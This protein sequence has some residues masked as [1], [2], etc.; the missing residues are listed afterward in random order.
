MGDNL[1]PYRTER[2]VE[3]GVRGKDVKRLAETHNG[4]DLF[5]K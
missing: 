1:E 5:P 2:L 3:K 4:E